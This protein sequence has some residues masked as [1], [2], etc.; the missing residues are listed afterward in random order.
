MCCREGSEQS[1]A[2]VPCQC[3]FNVSL[4]SAAGKC[5]GV[6]AYAGLPSEWLEFKMAVHTS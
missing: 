2:D 3:H 1:G 4:V 6:Q 5:V